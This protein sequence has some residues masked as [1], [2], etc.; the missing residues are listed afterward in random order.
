M[1]RMRHCPISPLLRIWMNALF[2]I[3][4]FS[5]SILVVSL[6]VYCCCCKQTRS[7]N[8]KYTQF[9]NSEIV[10]FVEVICLATPSINWDEPARNS[11]QLQLLSRCVRMCVL[12]EFYKQ[13]SHFTERKKQIQRLFTM[14]HSYKTMFKM[15]FVRG[16]K[17][18]GNNSHDANCED[19]KKFTLKKMCVH[20]SDWKNKTAAPHRCYAIIKNNTYAM[21]KTTAF[22]KLQLLNT[23][24][25]PIPG[26][27]MMAWIAH[28]VQQ[29]F[30]SKAAAVA[31]F[32]YFMFRWAYVY[33]RCV[34]IITNNY[35]CEC[36]CVWMH[37]H[38]FEPKP[39]NTRCLMY[40]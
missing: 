39:N 25:H 17:L 29:L 3:F 7:R 12:W 1:A 20:M 14:R 10:K 37:L 6:F 19:K 9:C 31:T 38:S 18:D 4:V 27:W 26:W 8:G 13:N 21:W 34:L 22:E 5:F 28:K 24:T 33:F 32:H 11:P 36:E 2:H 16:F 40:M 15:C 35:A 30:S 23:L